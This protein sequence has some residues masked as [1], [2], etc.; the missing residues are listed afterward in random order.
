[1]P[2]FRAPLSQMNL[3]W[4]RPAM[5]PSP[6]IPMSVGEIKT[7]TIRLSYAECVAMASGAN[8]RTFVQGVPGQMIVPVGWFC[9]MDKVGAGTSTT[10]GLRYATTP[11][12]SPVSATVAANFGNGG[13]AAVRQMDME[14]CLNANFPWVAGVDLRGVS[15]NLINSSATTG[16]H[17]ASFCVLGLTYYLYGFTG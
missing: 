11:G 9:W 13:A 5:A 6:I 12:T 16:S 14:I 2:I 17:P 10:F 7:A 4:S 1:M 15:L 3:G 8:P